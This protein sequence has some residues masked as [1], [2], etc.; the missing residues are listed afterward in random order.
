MD[1]WFLFVPV[2]LF[3]SL[4][5]TVMGYLAPLVGSIDSTAVAAAMIGKAAES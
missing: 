2:P 3:N 4:L 1:A 5:E